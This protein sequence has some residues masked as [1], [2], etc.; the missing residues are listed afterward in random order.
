MSSEGEKLPD[1]SFPARPQSPPDTGPQEIGA[2][3]SSA[4]EG[5]RHQLGT[6]AFASRRRDT[7]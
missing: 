1:Q 5:S 6:E 7:V 2:D 3:V 4:L